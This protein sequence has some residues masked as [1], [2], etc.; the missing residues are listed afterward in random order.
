LE[1]FD[2]SVT[3]NVLLTAPGSEV[4]QA[5]QL[6]YSAT[7]GSYSGRVSVSA[8]ARGTGRVQVVGSVG[9]GLVSLFALY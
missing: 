2:A 4:A 7:T 6:S 5:P 8:S 1:Q 9:G 3:P